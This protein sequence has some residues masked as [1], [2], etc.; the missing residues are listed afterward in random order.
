M[1]RDIII[2]MNEHDLVT[3]DKSTASMPTFDSVWGNIFDEDKELDVLICNIIIPEAYWS[4]VKYEN[5]EMTCRFKAAYMPDTSN[6]R[7]RLV[8]LRYGRYS[9]F[10][11]IRGSFGLPVN[12]YALSKNIAI[13][14]SACMLPYIDLDGEYMI[15]MIQHGDS[16]SLDKAYIYSGKITD[17]N[18]D[19]SDNQASQLLSLC[20]PGKSYRYPTTGVGITKYLNCVVAHSDL[21][22]VLEVQFN[23]DSK[24]LQSA[25]FDNETGKLDVLFYPE[26]EKADTDL[27]AVENLDKDFFNLFTDE[28]L[29]RNIVLN[30]VGDTDFIAS[31]DN[32]PNILNILLFVDNYIGLSRI[33]NKVEAGQFNAVGEV[34]PSDQYFIVSATLEANTIIMF[35]DETADKIEEAPLFIIDDIDETPLY[36]SLIEQPY[37][38]TEKCHKCFILKRRSVIKYMISQEQFRAGKGLFAIP[39]ESSNIKNML[40]LAQDDNTGRLLALVS[41]NTNISDITLDEV[42]Q[43]IYANQISQSHEQ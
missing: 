23:G 40:V 9:L 21:Q 41:D 11:N 32:Y 31:L 22:K 38:L 27:E 39:R 43:Y 5:D 3:E 29:R 17:I 7:V 14:I 24:P 30:S 4:L 33:A 42:S 8:G 35:D 25:D 12:S 36:V 19:Y 6:F 1:V 28:Y 2:D 10:N 26:Q 37:W 20:G 13:P 18:I 34:I 16:E 15:K